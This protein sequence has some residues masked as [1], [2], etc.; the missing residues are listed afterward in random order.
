MGLFKCPNC[1]G[2]Y[3]KDGKCETCGFVIDKP[4]ENAQENNPQESK[5][6]HKNLMTC[7]DCG[8]TISKN[9]YVCPQCGHPFPK[10]MRGIKTD[11]KASGTRSGLGIGGTIIAIVI[12]A[13]IIWYIAAPYSTPI[14]LQK[15]G[16]TIKCFFTGETSYKIFDPSKIGH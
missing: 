10:N 15:I 1:G 4:I 7:P 11:S 5:Q 2:I 13:L 6:V 3:L 9:A 16:G 12:A 8:R 14:W